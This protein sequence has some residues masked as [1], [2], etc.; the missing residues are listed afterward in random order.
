MLCMLM[1]LCYVVVLGCYVMLCLFTY[2]LTN[3]ILQP[4]V[5][6]TILLTQRV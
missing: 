1:L 6:F 5:T 4:R 3:L 2:Q